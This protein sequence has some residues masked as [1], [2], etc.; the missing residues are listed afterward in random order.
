MLKLELIDA[1]SKAQEVTKDFAKLKHL[2]SDNDGERTL[3]E[4]HRT[5]GQ[6]GLLLAANESKDLAHPKNQAIK[7]PT[8][9]TQGALVSVRPVG[10]EYKKKTYLGFLIGEIALGSSITM[11]DGKIQ[12]NFSGH[13][14]AIFVPELGKVIYGCESWWGEIESEAELKEITDEDIDNVW[15][16]KLWKIFNE[17][18]SKKENNELDKL[19]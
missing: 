7:K 9:G 19:Q 3:A 8:F 10:E 6:I 4:L 11:E 12:L 14:P 13:N 1:I 5:L 16:V 15:Y 17:R 2:F 18:A